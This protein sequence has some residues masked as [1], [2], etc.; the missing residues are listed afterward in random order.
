MSADKQKTEFDSTTNKPRVLIVMGVS[1][2]GKTTLANE[3]GAA[4]GIVT[5]DADDF[6]SEGNKAHMASGL[7]L[8]DEMRLPW[9]KAIRAHLENEAA[10]GNSHVLAFS[11]LRQQHRN[12]LRINN[13]D[14]LFFFLHGPKELIA[15]R[16]NTREGHFMPS[17]LLDSQFEA[18]EL[19][20]KEQDVIQLD[21]N[22][23]MEAVLNQ[24]LASLSQID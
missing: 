23:P 3:L 14:V 11:G 1:G 17:T 18:L 16:M 15:K 13:A 7:P 10:A 8:S 2:S 24:A 21:T 5:L 20:H 4:L 9:V 22:A 19:P 12:L 6:H